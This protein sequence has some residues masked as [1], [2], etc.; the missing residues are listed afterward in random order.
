MER[1]PKRNEYE[2]PP[3]YFVTPG[4]VSLS[5][6]AVIA[7]KAFFDSLHKYEPKTR[8]IA[9]FDWCVARSMQR[10]K[11]S[12]TIDEG[13]GIDLGGYRYG[14]LQT[15]T[16]QIIGGVPIVIILPP[17]VVANAVAKTIVPVR[18]ESGRE[19]FTLA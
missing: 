16:V 14:E 18:L 17:E 5:A 11:D 10:S 19:S 15:D 13:P 2:I 4:I 6:D 3:G 7:A 9:G 1:P 12:E 8:W